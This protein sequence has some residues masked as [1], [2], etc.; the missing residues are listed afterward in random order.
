MSMPPARMGTTYLNFIASH[1]GI[2]LRPVEG[3][4]NEE[5]LNILVSTMS[6]FGGRIS[7]RATDS[8]IHKPYEMNISL[9]DA[10]QGS[11]EHGPDRWQ[12]QRFI[13]AHTIMIALEGVP[14]FYIHSFLGTENDYKKRLNQLLR[15]NNM[16]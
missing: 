13:C 12:F 8:G 11:V 5:E 6:S 2:G 15:G 10:M 1:D 16:H 9:F 3:L 7:T 14:A 4:L